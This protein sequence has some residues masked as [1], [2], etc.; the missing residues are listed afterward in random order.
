MNDLDLDHDFDLDWLADRRPE[1]AAPDDATTAHARRTLLAYAASDR[2]RPRAAAPAPA[3]RASARRRRRPPRI[4]AA[5]AVSAVA[6]VLTASLLPAG[7]DG[8]AG[9]GRRATALA[10]Q[11][12]AAAPLVRLSRKLRQA[13]PAQT[14]DATLVLRKHTFPDA[15]A[16]TGADLYLDDGR[17][18][19][20]ATLPDLRASA[21]ADPD[22]ETDDGAIKRELAAA[23]AAPAL[24]DAD[25]RA[26]MVAA[27][28]AGGKAPTASPAPPA[29]APP[30]PATLDG[31]V[32]KQLAFKRAHPGSWANEKPMTQREIDDNRI[33]GASMDALAAGPGRPDVRAGVLSLLA[34]MPSVIVT[35]ST[36]DGR[37][38]LRLRCTEFPQDY[39][40][41][42]TVDAG[43]GVLLHFEG[44]TA[45]KP[46]SVTVT[47]D[48]KRVVAKDVLAG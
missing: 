1:P 10:P 45:G 44:G 5:A 37:A 6:V 9:G 36:E 29:S 39:E 4:L 16:F 8:T 27:T 30:A 28:W 32:K 15:P 23:V 46:P 42:L 26:R 43:T 25:A 21:A 11:A 35:P 19:Y 14:G 41:T 3:R 48:V 38:V 22:Q 47:Y 2:P 20:G 7:G 33:W 17:Y 34:T 24:S 12:A 40:E 18:F 31:A 13:P